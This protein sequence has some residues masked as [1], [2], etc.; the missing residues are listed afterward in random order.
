MNLHS[1]VM[2]WGLSFAFFHL[3]QSKMLVI[4]VGSYIFR[5]WWLPFSS[6]IK[7][8]ECVF[9]VAVCQRQL[10]SE[11][12]GV[13]GWFG[14]LMPSSIFGDSCYLLY[15]FVK[16]IYILCLYSAQVYRFE[17]LLHVYD[18]RLVKSKYNLK[19]MSVK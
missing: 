9:F 2:Q 16:L 3:F 4:T 7:F 15:A 11:E 19:M 13:N 17:I 14:L 8:Q 6:H 10:L 1:L 18:E 12:F 5:K